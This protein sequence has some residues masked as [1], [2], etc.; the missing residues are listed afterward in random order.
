MLI[1]TK[2]ILTML[3]VAGI[4]VAAFPAKAA[5]FVEGD[6]LLAFRASTGSNTILTVNLGQASQFVSA[7]TNS[8]NISSVIDISTILNST[9]GTNWQTADATLNWAVAGINNNTAVGGDPFRTAYLSLAQDG[10]VAVGTQVTDA[11]G[12]WGTL[13]STARGTLNSQIGSAEGTFKT[14]T[15]SPTRVAAISNAVTTWDDNV[16]NGFGAGSTAEGNFATG[17]AGTALDLYRILNST[18]GASPTGTVGVAAWQGTFAISTAGVVSFN[19]T[20]G[21]VP[22]PSRALLAALGL[23]GLL[24]RRRRSLK[25]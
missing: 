14:A 19:S 25:A 20:P 15:E 2:H 10:A 4:S 7:H 24:L 11:A 1:Q 22:E 16:T 13:G 21:A 8:T 12:T 23:G 5:T 6:I 3:V 17:A 9:Y 18:S